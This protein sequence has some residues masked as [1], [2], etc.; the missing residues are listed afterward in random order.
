VGLEVESTV[1]LLTEG[2]IILVMP[3]F[4]SPSSVR[5]FHLL[6]ILSSDVAKHPKEGLDQMVML[7][8]LISA[9]CSLAFLLTAEFCGKVTGDS[10]N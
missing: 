6:L 7:Y 1:S 3:H 5:V 8:Y 10:L 9:P 2:P 4:L